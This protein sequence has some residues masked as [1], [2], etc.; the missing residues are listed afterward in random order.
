MAAVR[1]SYGR[2]ASYA[3]LQSA[4]SN[5]T[6]GC[7]SETRRLLHY[8]RYQHVTRKATYAGLSGGSGILEVFPKTT[9]TI[10]G[11][12]EPNRRSSPPPSMFSLSGRCRGVPDRRAY[13]SLRQ[14]SLPVDVRL[15][16]RRGRLGDR[17]VHPAHAAAAR[18]AAGGCFRVFGGQSVVPWELALFLVEE[19]CLVVYAYAMI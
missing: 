14:Q 4:C 7:I 12:S 9:C 13:S 18:I 8:M 5:G 11:S 2:V 6:H 1:Q 17:S 15:G 10:R 16:E 3:W 19:V